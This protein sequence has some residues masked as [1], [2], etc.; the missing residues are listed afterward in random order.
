MELLRNLFPLFKM[1]PYWFG[2]IIVPKRIE[3]ERLVP[4]R[5]ENDLKVP[6]RYTSDKLHKYT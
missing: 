6:L 5:I 4:K 2:S 1:V 3:I